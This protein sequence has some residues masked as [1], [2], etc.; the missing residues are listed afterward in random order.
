MTNEPIR[1]Y[2][3]LA[4]YS[5]AFHRVARKTQIDSAKARD[6]YSDGFNAGW[7]AYIEGLQKE[8]PHEAD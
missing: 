3:W 6:E 1:S 4:G 5:D 2:Y 8:V 7:T